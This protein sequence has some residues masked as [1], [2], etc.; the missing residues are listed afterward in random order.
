[1]EKF[2][3]TSNTPKDATRGGWFSHQELEAWGLNRH[4]FREREV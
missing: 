3:D 2:L 4:I 1:M